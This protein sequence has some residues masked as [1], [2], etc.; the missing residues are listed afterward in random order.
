MDIASRIAQFENMA[1]ADPTN[2]MAHFSLGQAYVQAGRQK[3]AAE[4]FLRC[5]SINPELS[6]AYQLAGEALIKSGDTRKAAAVLAQ[7]YIIAAQK[8]D[9][10]PK[11]AM[12]TLLRSMGETPPEVQEQAPKGAGAAAADA[13]PHS[14]AVPEGKIVCRQTSR[15]G[16]RFTRQPFK[17]P[18][19]A[20]IAAN[21]SKETFDL[22][23][24]QGTKVINELRLDLSRD[25]DQE[26]YDQHMREFL[27][28]DDAVLAEITAGKA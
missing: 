18:V 11:N 25:K 9:L 22:W 5:V 1:Q 14:G 2:E 6:K 4:S 10:M 8:G 24:K 15:L 3:D 13:G 19:G 17:G 23:I 12:G 26:V 7:G 21:I 28:I 20:W 16:T 27:G